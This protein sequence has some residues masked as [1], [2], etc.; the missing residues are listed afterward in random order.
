VNVSFVDLLFGLPLSS[1][2]TRLLL[3]KPSPNIAAMAS[4]HAELIRR[5]KKILRQR[6]KK[7]N[8][9]NKTNSRLGQKNLDLLFYLNYLKFIKTLANKAN[10]IAVV[11]GASEVMPQHWRES[12][13]AI[14]H[15]FEQENKLK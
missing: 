1:Y 14:L 5:H 4:S 3:V 11:E 15:T 8:E 9:D 7:I 12:G 6:L 2:F 10:Q 13:D